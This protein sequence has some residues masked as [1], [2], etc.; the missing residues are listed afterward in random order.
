MNRRAG[1]TLIELMIVV[2][3]VGI[4]AMIAVPAFRGYVM[5]ARMTEGYTM[6]GEI[7]E[8]EEAY[9]GEFGQYCGNLAWNPTTYAPPSGFLAFDTA[10]PSWAQLGVVPDGPVRFQYNVAV[11]VPGT[12]PSGISG[13]TGDDYWFVIQ[14]QV[15]LDGDGTTAVLEG[16]SP[17]HNLYLSRG[18]GGPLLA[19]G[20]E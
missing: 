1:F 2:A 7:R 14:G 16:Y 17:A 3:I 15:D 4:L 11:G 12:T 20:W 10:E 19:Q 6:L 9:R 5:R 13:F 8:R 18:I